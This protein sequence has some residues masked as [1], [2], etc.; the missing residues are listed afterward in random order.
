MPG[1]DVQV[2]ASERIAAFG[3]EYEKA[4]GTK[5]LQNVEL[6]IEL[7]MAGCEEPGLEEDFSNLMKKSASLL[8]QRRASLLRLQSLD[9]YEQNRPLPGPIPDQP[10]S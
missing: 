6:S 3:L 5:S 2:D 4:A 8:L 1:E 10:L 7:L 9:A